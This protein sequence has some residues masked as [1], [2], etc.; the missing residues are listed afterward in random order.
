[1]Q[2]VVGIL[3]VPNINISSTYRYMCHIGILVNKLPFLA[4]IHVSPAKANQS[5]L[6]LFNLS[7]LAY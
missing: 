7:I 4:I 1:M 3:N 6:F 2:R 5:D